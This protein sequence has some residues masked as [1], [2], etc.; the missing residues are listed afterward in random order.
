MQNQYETTDPLCYRM[1]CNCIARWLHRLAGADCFVSH[2]LPDRCSHTTGPEFEVA[3]HPNCPD[4][5]V[6]HLGWELLVAQMIYYAQSGSSH[7]PK[8]LQGHL[9][10]S[11]NPRSGLT[12]L[13]RAKVLRRRID[14][15][16][17]LDS[18]RH[19]KSTLRSHNFAPEHFRC[20]RN[21]LSSPHLGAALQRGCQ[22]RRR[23]SVAVGI[24]RGWIDTLFVS[25]V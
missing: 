23:K 25:R 6:W 10:A 24:S 18:L 11:V 8:S 4:S 1:Y 14:P 17:R 22:I 5:W 15:S 2:L 21:T 19:H 7:G 13:Q 12:P 9:W 16:L 3:E 20:P